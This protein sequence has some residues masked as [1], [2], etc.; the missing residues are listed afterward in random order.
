MDIILVK[1]TDGE[2]ELFD[3]AKHGSLPKENITVKGIHLSPKIEKTEDQLFT[4]IEQEKSIRFFVSR[5]LP[6]AT[7]Y[8]A[9]DVRLETEHFTPDTVPEV[10]NAEKLIEYWESNPNLGL[11]ARTRDAWAE[12]LAT[13]LELLS[14]DEEHNSIISLESGVSKIE[15]LAKTINDAK[16]TQTVEWVADKQKQIVEWSKSIMHTFEKLEKIT[17]S[18]DGWEYY[19]LFNLASN[20]PLKV[21]RSGNI[22][23]KFETFISHEPFKGNL[24]DMFKVFE[25]LTFAFSQYEDVKAE[26]LIS[27]KSAPFDPAYQT[28]L[29][30]KAWGN[31]TDKEIEEI[32]NAINLKKENFDQKIQEMTERLKTLMENLK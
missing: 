4:L 26:A 7:N 15:S 21:R 2:V 31:V 24:S 23:Q 20:E 10:V 29:A 11:I 6:T 32:N 30:I 16:K 18:S 22:L 12:E 19:T 8:K 9:L 5:E 3:K 13:E 1:N 14:N 25:E 28:H 27:A 17:T